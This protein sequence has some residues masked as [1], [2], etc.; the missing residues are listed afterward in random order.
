MNKYDTPDDFIEIK[1]LQ[2]KFIKWNN[3]MA[4]IFDDRKEFCAMSYDKVWCCTGIIV[5]YENNI[6]NDN[7][8]LQINNIFKNT[9]WEL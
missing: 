7:P 5:D 3:L 4:N 6:D 1:D 9:G 2:A 8:M